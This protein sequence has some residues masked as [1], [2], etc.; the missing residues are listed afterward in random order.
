[1][2]G[3]FKGV[4]KFALGGGRF[5]GKAG[6]KEE[7]QFFIIVLC[8]I[9]Y[10]VECRNKLARG[11]GDESGRLTQVM[12]KAQAGGVAFAFFYGCA[13]FPATTGVVR[14][15]GIQLVAHAKEGVE[16][17]DGSRCERVWTAYRNGM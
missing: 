3:H 15:F 4:P 6:G 8:K 5:F 10:G 2:V 14:T 1:M 12:D 16:V 13:F 11:R 7:A 9:G 17:F